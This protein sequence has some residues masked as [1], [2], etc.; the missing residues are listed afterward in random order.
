MH[1]KAVETTCNI[2]NAFGP[3]TA[4]ACTVQW[5]FKKFCKGEESFETWGAQWL[6]IRSWQWPIDQ[7]QKKLS[8]N[9]TLTILWLLGIWSRLKRQKRLNKGVPCEM[10]ANQKK[11]HFE[12]PSSLI[13]HNNK[14]FFNQIVICDEKWIFDNNQRWPVHPSVRSWRN[15]KALPKAK[16]A[17][18]RSWSLFGGLLLVWSTTAFWIPVKPL[19][20]R[21]TLSKLMRGTENCKAY[22]DRKSVV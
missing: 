1:R 22:R 18:K 2:N 21:R 12:V 8:K 14:T 17:P 15:P 13:L 20:L 4:N 5:W 11:C 7:L 10:T 16:L 9:S 3:A 6:A 19:H